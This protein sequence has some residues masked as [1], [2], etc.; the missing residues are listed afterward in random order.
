MKLAL[1]VTLLL[2]LATS[3]L[4][5]PEFEIAN[6]IFDFGTVSQNSH[7]VHYFWFKSTGDD[8]VKIERIVTGC[9]CTLADYDHDVLPPGDSMLVG[10][11]WDLD[12]RIGFTS[13]YPRVYHNAP[14]SPTSMTIKALAVQ[15]ADTARPV[16]AKPYKAELSVAEPIVVDSV[17]IKLHN[18][19]DHLLTVTQISR[20]VAWCY[21]DL[22]DT[23][24]A[25]GDA[26]IKVKVKPEY[27]E[28][29][30][31]ASVTFS[32]AKVKSS[33]DKDKPTIMTI[34][35]RRKHYN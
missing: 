19:L 12:R 28:E 9:H 29:D 30:F 25:N 21:V 22:P 26:W 13:Q 17:M 5:G 4:A 32:M 6:K 2:L 27:A 3:V 1:A 8:T 18:Y 10:I 14:H 15:A 34:P 20:D 11:S 31:V 23:I 24:P 16:S 33:S 35:I 7:V